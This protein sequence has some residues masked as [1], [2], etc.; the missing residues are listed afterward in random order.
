MTEITTIEVTDDLAVRIV[1][2]DKPYLLIDRIVGGLVRIEAGE[3]R[4]LVEVLILAG[5]D[6]AAL[7]TGGKGEAGD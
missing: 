4:H 2:G 7:A 1:A 5:G 3:I 6:L